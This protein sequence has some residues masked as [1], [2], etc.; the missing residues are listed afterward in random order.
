[1]RTCRELVAA[2]GTQEMADD[3]GTTYGVVASWKQRNAIPYEWFPRVVTMAPVAGF[4]NVTLEVLH[5]L[6]RGPMP[7]AKS[8]PAKKK[9]RRDERTAV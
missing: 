4:P 6:R 8:T 2:W 5:S 3:L 1:M 7:K 9:A